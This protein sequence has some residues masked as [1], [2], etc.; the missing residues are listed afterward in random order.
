MKLRDHL[1]FGFEQTF[2]LPDW[3][4]EDGFTSVSDTPK[5]REKMLE[6]AEE[7]AIELSGE[8]KESKD[9]WDHMQ[10]E[11]TD[12]EGATQFY[13]TMDPGSIEVKTPPCLI[14]EVEAMAVPLFSASERSGLVPYRNWW[15]GVKSGTEGGCHVNMG[16][17]T[18]ETNPLYQMPEL[19]VKYAAYI[20]NRPFLHWPFMG[21]DV[22]PGGNA[23]RM[24]EKD[25]FSGVKN[26]FE[27]YRELYANGGSLSASETFEFFEQTN[28]INDKSSFPS[29]KKFTKD[30]FLIED[31]GQEAL[32]SPEE[33][34]L[35]C[36]LA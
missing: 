34:F 7:L 36:K 3:W 4:T 26:R 17:H 21:V 14:D 29:L 31:R 2:T 13:V 10:Y 22:G 32:R 19:V 6:L 18:L 20:H 1:T 5:K 30:L 16:G 11:V 8:V 27:E 28:L 35:V 24:D 12:S 9:I 15:Y 33:F 25:D 23:M